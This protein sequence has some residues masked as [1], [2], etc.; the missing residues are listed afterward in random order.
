MLTA[1]FVLEIFKF[2]PDVL[3]KRL[4]KKAKRLI[5]KLMTSQTG[6]KII[7]IHILFN[8]SRKKATR[9]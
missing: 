7:T 3:V 4:D 1:L 6:Q 5:S 2:L 9:Q 8:I